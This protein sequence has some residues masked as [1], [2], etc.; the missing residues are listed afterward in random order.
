MD[1]QRTAQHRRKG[2][3]QT[4]KRRFLVVKEK[5]SNHQREACRGQ[6][7]SEWSIGDARDEIHRQQ[8]PREKL[9][10]ASRRSKK[11]LRGQT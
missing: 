8:S 1:Q 9:P 4:R 5:R 6:N 11:A 7:L 3:A 2:R 10:A